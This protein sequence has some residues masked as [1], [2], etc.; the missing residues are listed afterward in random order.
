MKKSLLVLLS[1]VFFA[2]GFAGLAY[3]WGMGAPFEEADCSLALVQHSAYT[4]KST[5]KFSGTCKGGVTFELSGMWKLSEKKA[6]ESIKGT[7]SSSQVTG[8]I[9]ATCPTGIDP[10][11]NVALCAAG[12]V[13]GNFVNY[14]KI[15]P[16]TQYPLSANKLSDAQKAGFRAEAQANGPAP[17]TPP[18]PPPPP[19]KK[20]VPV[21]GVK[22]KIPAPT[23]VQ[24]T[25]GAVYHNN[26]PVQVRPP[27]GSSERIVKL[28]FQIFQIS[29][30]HKIGG[31]VTKAVVAQYDTGVNPSGISIPK[32]QFPDRGD[33]RIRAKMATSHEALW[34][35]WVRFKL[36]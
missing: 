3:G 20:K 12:A 27:S 21:E 1:I 19:P 34:S 26:V 28:E 17:A 36:Q 31:F 10:W 14:F 33:W 24:P 6:Y 13:S 25:P 5:W 30:T 22:P 29:Q 4:D 16:T 2:A 23:I 35:G 11:L 9:T 7:G 18:P 32:N 8:A 15:Y